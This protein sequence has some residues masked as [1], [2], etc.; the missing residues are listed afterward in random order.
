MKGP[1]DGEVPPVQSHDRGNSQTLRGR[2][3]RRVNRSQRLIAVPVDKFR[4]AQPVACLDRFDFEVARGQISEKPYLCRC[5]K[6][7]P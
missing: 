3:D 7:G 6:T 1:D 2:H 4:Y 5:A